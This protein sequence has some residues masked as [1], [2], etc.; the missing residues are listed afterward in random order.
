[1]GRHSA[2][3]FEIKHRLQIS[4]KPYSD[5]MYRQSISCDMKSA[6]PQPVAIVIVEALHYCVFLPDD[7]LA[8]TFVIT[9][10]ANCISL[11]F[12]WV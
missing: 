6:Q 4:G 11:Y 3:V 12:N 2:I 9:S 7:R 10:V 1:M 8:V 5:I